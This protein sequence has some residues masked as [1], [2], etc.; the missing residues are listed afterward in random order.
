VF[1]GARGGLVVLGLERADRLGVLLG[2][3]VL[4]GRGRGHVRAAATASAAPAGG[5]RAGRGKRRQRAGQKHD[6]ERTHVLSSAESDHGYIP[7]DV[8]PVQLILARCN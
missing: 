2:G 4:R 3:V 1:G 7:T 6:P 5:D 8:A